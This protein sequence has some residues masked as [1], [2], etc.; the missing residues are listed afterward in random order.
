MWAVATRSDPATDIDIIRQ[1]WGSMVDPQFVTY[2]GA[3]PQ[4]APFN[5]RA[6]V[7]ACIPSDHRNDFPPVAESDPVSLEAA[8]RKWPWITNPLASPAAE[9]DASEPRR[10][11]P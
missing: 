4:G 7:D 8:R 10:A 11:V 1:A 9:T 6:I 3:D 5:S 2:S